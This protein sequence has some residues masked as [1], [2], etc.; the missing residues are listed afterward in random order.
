MHIKKGKHG[1]TFGFPPPAMSPQSPEE[2]LIIGNVTV[3]KFVRVENV[4]ENSQV[5]KHV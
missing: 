4:A 5:G 2:A 3:I 1:Y